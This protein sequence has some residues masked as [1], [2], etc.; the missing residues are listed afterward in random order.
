MITFPFKV[1]LL[2]LLVGIILGVAGTLWLKSRVSPV[3]CPIQQTSVTKT[4]TDTTT[5]VKV[6]AT[7]SVKVT[8]STKV[9]PKIDIPGQKT[10]DVT[11]VTEITETS[12]TGPVTETRESSKQSSE[13]TVS[14][15]KPRWMVGVGVGVAPGILNSVQVSGGIR[16]LGDIYGVVTLSTALPLQL[17]VPAVGVGLQILLN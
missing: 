4:A 6:P 1:P 15:S 16:V 14:V 12:E 17:R 10:G 9:A 2:C 3:T 7:R 8:K 11:E 5:V 13:Q